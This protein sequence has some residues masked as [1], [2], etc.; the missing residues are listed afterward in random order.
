MST[1]KNLIG[2]DVNSLTADPDN[3]AAEG[4]I[5][6]NS[7]V[8]QFKNLIIGEA[9]SSGA[10]MV[11]QS[12][13]AQLNL[14]TGIQTAALVAGGYSPYSNLTE[15]YNGSGWTSGGNLSTARIT[16]GFGTQ[17]AGVAVGGLTP[18]NTT[19]GVSEEYDGSSWT[20]GGSLNTARSYSG[21]SGTLTAGVSF[22][23][24]TPPFTTSNATEEYNGTAF[25][26]VNNMNVYGRHM[27]SS[28]RGPQTATL[29]FGGGGGPTAPIPAD[30][31]MATTES[32]DG[33]N[34][35][36]VNSMNT[37]RRALGSAGIQTSA[38]A[39]GGSTPPNTNATES[40]DGTNWTTSP[41]TLANAR[42][43]P[44]SIGTSSSALYAGGAAPLFPSGLVEEYTRS[45]NVISAAAWSSGGN[46]STFRY[47]GAGGGT[48]T[49]AFYGGGYPTPSPA[50]T[51]VTEE[52]NG[53]SWSGGGNMN[54]AR[55]YTGGS[56]TLTAGLA[57]GGDQ[58]PSPRFSVKTEEYNGTSWAEQNDLPSQNKN[59]GSCGTQTASL[60]FG[61]NTPGATNVNNL[62]DGTNWTNTGHNLNTARYSLRGAGTSTAALA[63]GSDSGGNPGTATEEYNGSSW[64]SVNSSLNSFAAAGSAGTQT[65]AAT[66][67]GLGPTSTG[68]VT[69]NNYDGTTWTTAP[70]LTMA[71]F[72]T[73]MG[74]IGTQTAALCVAG[75]SPS[76]PASGVATEEFTAESSALNIKTITTS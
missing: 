54:T 35:T 56:G 48:Q 25:T 20:A 49:A 50:A 21:G 42:N 29:A 8:G 32:Y 16:S 13:S 64:T 45:I 11:R 55:M 51:N 7:T 9:W 70:G 10:A 72:Y 65:A 68:Q 43:T 6:Y 62:Y 73:A 66:F 4:Q 52:Y 57:S 18:P 53:S 30:T 67:G 19:T 36:A 34:W 37:A 69:N 61:G 23:G 14:G 28:G 58:Y 44:Q 60:N 75:N 74:P 22:G 59:M 47:A 15:E 24:L 71:R 31:N 39:F 26:S 17:T 3:D 63:M 5:W 40:W 27:G 33:T 76:S 38:L 12:A 41:A 1:Y 2:K 46:L